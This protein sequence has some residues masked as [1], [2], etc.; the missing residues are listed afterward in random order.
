MKKTILMSIGLSALLLSIPV[1][2]KSS[3]V[4]LNVNPI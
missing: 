3:H 4:S 1:L 2:A